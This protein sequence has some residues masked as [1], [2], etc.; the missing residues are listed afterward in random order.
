MKQTNNQF[1]IDKF[2]KEGGK[3]VIADLNLEA[4][5]KAA[6]ELK[7]RGLHAAAVKADILRMYL[8]FIYFSILISI[9]ILIYIF[10]C[11]LL[12]SSTNMFDQLNISQ[13]RSRSRQWYSLQWT[14]LVEL[15]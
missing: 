3:V 10:V 14:R 12:F 4:A 8:L 15:M 13:K 5:E 7:G 9:L 6:K 11:Y 1:L 2:A